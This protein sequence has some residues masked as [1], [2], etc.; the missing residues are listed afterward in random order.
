MKLHSH[1]RCKRKAGG[2]NK[3]GREDFSHH[4]LEGFTRP[5]TQLRTSADHVPTTLRADYKA[6]EAGLYKSTQ[7]HRA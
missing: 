5:S 4:F 7:K 1:S 3:A 6:R 2:L